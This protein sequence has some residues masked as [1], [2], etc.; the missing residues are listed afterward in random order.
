MATRD[1]NMI[2]LT[3]SEG[4]A[5]WLAIAA[6]ALAVLFLVLVTGVCF[7]M[8]IGDP[9]LLDA[10]RNSIY[11]DQEYFKAYPQD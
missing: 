6:I 10:Y 2:N 1:Q 3:V 9:D 4:G 8:V 11:P 7:F 5:K